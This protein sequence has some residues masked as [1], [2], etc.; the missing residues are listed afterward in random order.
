MKR[1]AIKGNVNLTKRQRTV[2]KDRGKSTA[3]CPTSPNREPINQNTT[4]IIPNSIHQMMTSFRSNLPV[5][6]SRLPAQTTPPSP[7]HPLQP[8]SQSPGKSSTLSQQRGITRVKGSSVQDPRTRIRRPVPVL[9]TSA[10]PIGVRSEVMTSSQIASRKNTDGSEGSLSDKPSREYS[11]YNGPQ[12]V[13]PCVGNALFHVLQPCGHRV[14]TQDVQLCGQNCRGSDSPFANK[15]TQ[16]KFACAVC[17]SKYVHEHYTA[18]KDLFVPSLD[19]LETALGG[20]KAGWKEKRI[21]R[22]GRVWKNDAIEEQRALEKL[23]RRCEA[24]FTDPDEEKLVEDEGR[25][26]PEVESPAEPTD[27]SARTVATLSCVET[28]TG[29]LGPAVV[30][31]LK[32]KSQLPVPSSATAVDQKAPEGQRASRRRTRIPMGP[33]LPYK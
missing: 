20:F 8:A 25:A 31:R 24:V 3:T 33:R 9:P 15:K 32:G 7:G 27:L 2:D 4:S 19:M 11:Q 18:K 14:M 5:P 28:K 21:A 13:E 22:M 30:K 1:V 16:A 6:G 17:I 26:T 12:L 10:S 29:R 23:G